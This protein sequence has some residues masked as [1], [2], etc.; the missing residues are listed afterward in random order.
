MIDRYHQLIIIIIIITSSTSTR[1]SKDFI[2]T[3][4]FLAKTS[5]PQ[6]NTAAAT[7]LDGTNGFS[8]ELDGCTYNHCCKIHK[9]TVF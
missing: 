1:W 5:H 6:N 3:L 2:F 7:T 8:G 9:D 4:V